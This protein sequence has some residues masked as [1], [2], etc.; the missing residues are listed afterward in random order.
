MASQSTGD[1]QASQKC[2]L[3]GLVRWHSELDT[4]GSDGVRRHLLIGVTASAIAMFFMLVG[5]EESRHAVDRWS[6]V[7]ARSRPSEYLL[8][9]CHP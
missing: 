3:A 1:H 8:R 6:R 4:F 7:S 2:G 9:A 5:H